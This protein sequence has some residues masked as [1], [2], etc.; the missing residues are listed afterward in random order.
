MSFGGLALA[1]GFALLLAELAGYILHR[2]MH[3]ERFPTLSR[4][5]MIHHIEL[6]APDKSMRSAEYKD[7]TD[8]RVSLGNIGME[9]VLPSATILGVCWATMWGLRIA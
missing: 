5:H 1:V 4:A 6:Y 3:N 2:V 9:W 8:G 7:A